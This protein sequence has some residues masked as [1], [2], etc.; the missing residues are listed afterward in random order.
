MIRAQE[1]VFA[2]IMR[3]RDNLALRRDALQEELESTF[4]RE[5]QHQLNQLDLIL[6]DLRTLQNTENI[7]LFMQSLSSYLSLLPVINS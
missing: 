7:D 5:K 1:Y 6:A 3:L 4:S 2:R